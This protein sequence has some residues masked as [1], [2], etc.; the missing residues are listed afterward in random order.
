MSPRM[1]KAVIN[2]LLI[3]A[4]AVAIAPLLYMVSVSF[5]TPGEASALPPPV[6]PTHWTLAN[7]RQLFLNAGMGRYL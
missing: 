3:A 5:M 7:Y 6:L 1:A 2:G 4:A